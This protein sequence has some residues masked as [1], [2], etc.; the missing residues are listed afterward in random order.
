VVWSLGFRVWVD[1]SRC[2]CGGFGVDVLEIERYECQQVVKHKEI[3]HLSQQDRNKKRDS[4]REREG[5][6][7]REGERGTE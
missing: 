3:H 7:Y 2:R 6:R 5:D 4:D 1:R